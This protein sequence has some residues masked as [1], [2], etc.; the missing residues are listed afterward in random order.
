MWNEATGVAEAKTLSG[1]ALGMVQLK[2]L[3]L[4]GLSFRDHPINPSNTHLVVSVRD[5]SKYPTSAPYSGKPGPDAQVSNSGMLEVKNGKRYTVFN[6]EFQLA[7][8]KTNKA[9]VVVDVVDS[10]TKR[11]RGTAVLPLNQFLDQQVSKKIVVVEPSAEMG[12]AAPALTGSAGGSD[13]KPRHALHLQLRFQYSK[14]KPIKE[15]LYQVFEEK[16]AIETDAAALAL[17]LEC[18][19]EPMWDW[20][21]I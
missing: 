2:V 19:A 11:K 10:R 8:V 17:G 4:E 7:P 5:R 6:Q 16:R 21:G 20:E 14:T 3:S 13:E 18:T 15:E 9:E 1:L 12:V